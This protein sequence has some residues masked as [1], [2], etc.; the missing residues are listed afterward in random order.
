MT[1]VIVIGID[2]ATFNVILPMIEQGRLPNIERLMKDGAYGTLQSVTPP[3]SAPA[4]ASFQ[5]GL[6]PGNHPIFDFVVK[7]PE[8][9]KTKYIN[10]SNLKSPRLWD[11]L[12]CYSLSSIII[13]CMITYPPHRVKGCLLTGGLTPE[14]R[15]FTYPSELQN[16]ILKEFGKYRRWGVGGISCIPGKETDFATEY[17]L[18]ENRRMHIASYLMEN[19]PWDFFMVMFEGAD[20]LQHELWKYLD[21]DNEMREYLY[22]FYGQIDTYIGSVTSKYPDAYICIMSDHG[23]GELERYF[24]VNN[25]LLEN[26]FLKLKGGASQL[27]RELSRYLSLSRIYSLSKKLGLN[28]SAKWFRGGFKESLLSSLVTSSKDIDWSRTTAYAVGA[29]GH[30]YLNIKGREPQGVVNPGP[31]LMAVRR[32]IVEALEKVVDPLKGTRAV[33]KVFVKEELYRGR[34][35]ETAPDIAFLPAKGFSTLHREQFV[36]RETFIDSFN[37]GTHRPEGICIIKGPGIKKGLGP[38]KITDLT[39]T[40]LSM[41]GIY[42]KIQFDGKVLDEI[43]SQPPP[44]HPLSKLESTAIKVG[45][46]TRRW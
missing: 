14:G 45:R 41:F 39:P 46:L 16:E 17:I 40:I 42:P 33:E 44:L 30:I 26:G 18:N 7:E 25:F 11:I 43:Y 27:K 10:G 5:T 8:T 36:S 20:P 34:F 22:L 38:A 12:G 37:C 24:I 23:F 9:Y 19:K 6:N 2:G 1:K 13:N 3:S 32:Q 21:S 35:F 31:E 4:W 29:C 15:N 28:R